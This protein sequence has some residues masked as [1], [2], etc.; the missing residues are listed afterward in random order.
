MRHLTALADFGEVMENDDWVVWDGETF[1]SWSTQPHAWFV[2]PA[3]EV[4]RITSLERDFL[5]DVQ[6]TPENDRNTIVRGADYADEIGEIR[7]KM[8]ATAADYSAADLNTTGDID[9]FTDGS[10][11][12]GRLGIR[13]PGNQSALLATL[14]SLY[15]YVEDGGQFTRLLNLNDDFAFQGDFGAESDY[16]ATRDINYNANAVLRIYRGSHLDRYNIPSLDVSEDN[17]SDEVQRK[18]NRTDTGGV[19]DNQRLT[20]VESKV[21]ALFPLTPD[22]DKLTEWAEGIGTKRETEAVD[23]VQGYSLIADFRDSATRYE[24]AGVTY[25]R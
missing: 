4:R 3:H 13:L 8:Y 6:T 23:I 11:T 22:V 14:P 20:A 15:V 16:L 10:D 17:L 9:E 12:S 5:T 24:S 25:R 1:T 18:L 2:I 19:V 21:D 7:L